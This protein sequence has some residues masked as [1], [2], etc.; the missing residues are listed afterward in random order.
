M[1]THR[2][3]PIDL[4]YQRVSSLLLQPCMLHAHYPSLSS[5]LITQLTFILCY[6]YI[7]QI[8]LQSQLRIFVIFISVCSQHVSA[9]T[10]H[11]QVKYNNIKLTTK[12]LS[13][14]VTSS[15]FQ[16]T[17]TGK[18]FMILIIICEQKIQW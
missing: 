7:S 9:P 11:P 1:Q 18:I 6:T 8:Y 3:K 5:S 4:I 13:Y 16:S 14:S 12:I 2:H 17:F 10:G 15:L